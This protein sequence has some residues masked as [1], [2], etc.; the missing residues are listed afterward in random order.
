MCVCALVTH[1]FFGDLLSS[2]GVSF[3]SQEVYVDGGGGRVV[4][5]D[6]PGFCAQQAQETKLV[7]WNG[8]GELRRRDWIR[9]IQCV[10]LFSPPLSSLTS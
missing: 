8:A 3:G 1:L 4:G 7:D 6:L 2:K 5:E 9:R 10:S